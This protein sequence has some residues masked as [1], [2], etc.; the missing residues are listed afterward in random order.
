M[1]APSHISMSEKELAL[2]QQEVIE[3]IAKTVGISF[4]AAGS[5]LRHFKWAERD[6]LRTIRLVGLRKVLNNC[7]GISMDEI[8]YQTIEEHALLGTKPS[9]F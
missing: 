4:S 3:R 8:I 1:R 7:G 2:V 9:A 5:A 6:L